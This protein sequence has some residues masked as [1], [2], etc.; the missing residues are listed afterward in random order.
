MNS[1]KIVSEDIKGFEKIMSCDFPTWNNET[2]SHLILD[3]SLTRIMSI[4]TSE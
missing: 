4:S 2:R 3:Q 1:V